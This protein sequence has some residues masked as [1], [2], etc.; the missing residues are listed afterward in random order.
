MSYLHG[1]YGSMVPTKDLTNITASTLPVY[2]GVLPVHQKS[3]YSNLVNKPILISSY[4]DAIDQV[5]YNDSNWNDFDLCEAIYAHF[6]NDVQIIGPIVLINVLDPDTMKKTNLSAEVTFTNN[7][8]VIKNDKIILKSISIEDKVL[9]TDFSVEYSN[10]GTYVIITDLTKQMTTAT[11]AYEEV[12]ISLVAKD[13]II[14]GTND[15]TGIKTGISVVDLVYQTYNMVPTILNAPGWSHIPEVDS[16]LKE[17]SQLINGHWYAWV[18]SNLAADSN[19]GTISA[20]QTWKNNN[21][22]NSYYEAPCWPLALKNTRKFHLSTLT[23]V[24]MQWVDYNNDNIPY[25][26]PSNKEIDITGLC[27][28]DDTSIMF[29][30]NQANILNSKGI[31]TATYWGGKWVLWGSHTGAYSY[32]T[33]IDARYKFDC[34]MRM[35]YYILNNFQ[36]QYADKVDKPMN[37]SLIETI[38]NDYQAQLDALVSDGKLLYAIIQFTST[39]NPTSDLVEGDFT[40]DMATTTTP[41]GKSISAKLQYTSTGINTLFGSDS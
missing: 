25:E 41:P 32:G 21:G 35:L 18:N 17:A 22:Y 8:A 20:A 15:I 27:L 10:D 23:T 5:G 14:G 28:E 26:T 37:R 33:S 40:F 29:D 39:S 6:K 19:T 36:L 16:A 1:A 30:K 38:L 31:R 3:N 9:N 12:D 2:F 34:N 13:K 7:Q 24:T 11:I 4:D